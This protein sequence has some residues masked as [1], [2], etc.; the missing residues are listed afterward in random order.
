MEVGSGCGKKKEGILPAA[1][2]ERARARASEG[3]LL[4][5]F[6]GNRKDLARSKDMTRPKD[7]RSLLIHGVGQTSIGCFVHKIVCPGMFLS[8]VSGGSIF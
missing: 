6:G 8:L 7:I 2:E 4:R 3:A 1:G 5:N